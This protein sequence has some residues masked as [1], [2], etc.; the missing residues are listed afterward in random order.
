MELEW[1]KLIGKKVS[2]MISGLKSREAYIGHLVEYTDDS[3]CL[4]LIPQPVSPD[5]IDQIWISKQ[6][7][8]SVWI[9]AKE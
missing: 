2:V 7:I 5:P 6:I 4:K 8:L 1:E 9:Y 3:I